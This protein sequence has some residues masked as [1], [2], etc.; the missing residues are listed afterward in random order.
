MVVHHSIL[1]F[2]DSSTSCKWLQTA[3]LAA[4]HPQVIYDSLPL[5]E[6]RRLTANKICTIG[7]WSTTVLESSS[8]RVL[9]RVVDFSK[10]KYNAELYVLGTKN[11]GHSVP[12]AVF[13]HMILKMD[14]Y[15]FHRFSCYGYIND[16]KYPFIDP[17]NID[18]QFW[19]ITPYDIHRIC[20]KRKSKMIGCMPWI[21]HV[22]HQ[23]YIEKLL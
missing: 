14:F 16:H 3:L 18:R 7:H 13:S 11:T 17:I 8:Y 10:N 12:G 20:L 23:S 4:Y 1:I 15:Y 6:W 9:Y 21:S 2:F 22:N 5:S 19:K